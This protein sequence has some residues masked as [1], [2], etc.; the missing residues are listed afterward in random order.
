MTW[1]PA[2]QTRDFE[3]D[4]PTLLKDLFYNYW[5]IGDPAKE[6]IKFGTTWWDNTVPYQIHF[7]DSKETIEKA[8]LGWKRD[9]VHNFVDIHAFVRKVTAERPAELFHMYREIKRIVQ[10]NKSNVAEGVQWIRWAP[11]RELREIRAESDVDEAWHMT[12]TIE[13]FYHMVDTS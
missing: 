7:T 8:E 1:F 10:Q 11:V 5:A 3:H 9:E 12:G 2:G 6:N 4:V 13:C